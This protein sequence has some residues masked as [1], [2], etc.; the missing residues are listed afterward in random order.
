MTLGVFLHCSRP[1]PPTPGGL[2]GMGDAGEMGTPSS[3]QIISPSS[4]S[5]SAAPFLWAQLCLL[6][7]D[8]LCLLLSQWLNPISLE[9]WLL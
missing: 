2:S 9:S 3:P 7:R 6:E 1:L 8:L 5:E 4:P